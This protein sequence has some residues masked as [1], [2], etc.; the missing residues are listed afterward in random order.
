MDYCGTY[1]VLDFDG[2]RAW[3]FTPSRRWMIANDPG[4]AVSIGFVLGQDIN[5]NQLAAFERKGLAHVAD[6]AEVTKPRAW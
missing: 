4:H 3:S 5:E 6:Y 2:K 1:Y